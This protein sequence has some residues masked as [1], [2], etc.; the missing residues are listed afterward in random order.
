MVTFVKH[1]VLCFRTK[2]PRAAPPKFLKSLEILIRLWT[3]ILINYV[4]NLLEC[5]RNERIYKHVLVIVDRLTKMH[6]F[7][8]VINFTTEKLVEVFLNTIYKLHKI[9]DSIMLDRGS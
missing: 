6:H 7:I 4:I 3:N 9:S 2:T 1:C 8:S 5:P